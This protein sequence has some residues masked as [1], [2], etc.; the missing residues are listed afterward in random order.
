M[1]EAQTHACIS[2][3]NGIVRGIRIWHEILQLLK[4]T[5]N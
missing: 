3:I 1:S 4:K 2:G 5:T